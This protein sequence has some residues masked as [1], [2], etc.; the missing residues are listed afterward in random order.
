MEAFSDGVFAFAMTLLVL[1]LRDPTMGSTD[2][3]LKGLFGEWPAFLAFGISFTT[4]LVNWMNH[5][6]LFTYVRR[7][8]GSF[9][10]LN[11]LLLLA[12]TLIPFTTSL[13]A[14]HILLPDSGTAA[15][16][17]SGTFLLVAMAWNLLWQYAIRHPGI[18]ASS[19]SDAEI[20]TTTRQFLFGPML[21][22]VAFIAAFFS[23]IASLAINLVVL[24]MFAFFAAI[25]TIGGRSGENV[26]G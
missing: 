11:G 20:R 25:T 22:V 18:L 12:T 1:G 6:N 23:G 4:I 5:H 9:M 10:L 2:S 3:L 13:V 26:Q 8:D 16:V 17:Y 24:A 15:E 19:I 21:Y 14:D 7:I